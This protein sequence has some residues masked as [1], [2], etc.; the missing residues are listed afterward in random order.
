MHAFGNLIRIDPVIVFA[1]CHIRH[2][3]V[4]PADEKTKRI[5]TLF[6]GPDAL[7]GGFCV[8][9]IGRHFV[10]HT[11]V[12]RIREFFRNGITFGGIDALTA[13][14][15]L[16]FVELGGH[17]ARDIGGDEVIAGIHPDFIAAFTQFGKQ[18]ITAVMFQIMHGT[19]SVHMRIKAGQKTAAARHADRILTEGVFKRY[20]VFSCKGIQTRR[21]SGRIAHVAHGIPAHFIRIDNDNMRSLVH[22]GSF[23]SYM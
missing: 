3:R 23:R 10:N 1:V 9:Q 15:C 16:Q 14:V 6:D 13:F 20:G 4:H 18:C 11:D 22:K 5:I 12:V 8:S 2:V 21:G 19:K 7:A 17:Q